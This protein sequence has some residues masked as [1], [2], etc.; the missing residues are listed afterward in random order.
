MGVENGA[1]TT[2]VQQ[3]QQQQA[4]LWQRAMNQVKQAVLTAVMEGGRVLLPLPASGG[5]VVICGH[6]CVCECVCVC[7]CARWHVCM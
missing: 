1:G 4:G 7:V 3:Q 5:W 6:L 2:V